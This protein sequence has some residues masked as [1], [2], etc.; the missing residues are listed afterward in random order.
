MSEKPME[1]AA[2]LAKALFNFYGK[3]LTRPGA[4]VSE[5][6]KATQ[7]M[8]RSV[9]GSAEIKPEKGDKRW[10]DPVW[11]TNPAYRIMMQSYLAWVQGINSWVDRLDMSERDMMRVKLLTGLFTDSLAPT[12]ALLGNP[13][14]MKT[15]LEHGGANLVQGLKNFV[16]DMKD[17]NGLPSMVDKSKFELGENLALSP[18]KVV[19]TDEQIE[20]IQYQPQTAEVYK[21]P[22][23]VVP[24]QINKFY[25]WDLA[26]GRS[27][28]EY[29]TKAGHQVFIVSWAQ[30]DFGARAL[31]PELLYRGAG[32]RR[33]CRQP[34][35]QISNP[36]CDRRVLRRD[37]RRGD[38]RAVGRSG[39]AQA[40]EQLH[41]PRGHHRG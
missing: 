4:A 40:R 12:N 6:M 1:T 3:A 33:G 14:A 41:L 15:T 35:L 22:V 18:G 23:F 29:L 34:D 25:A 5:S 2:D 39:R 19:Y 31:G 32:S 27:V 36:Q 28:V 11:A 20:L 13:T 37:H 26:P 24:P 7:E 21:I 16:S 10:R 38:D 9:A 30:S 17:N 8:L